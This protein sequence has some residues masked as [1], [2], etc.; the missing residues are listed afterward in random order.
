MVLVTRGISKAQT[1]E[2]IS[3][4]SLVR[5]D[6]TGR[7]YK[8]RNRPKVVSNDTIQERSRRRDKLSLWA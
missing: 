7:E 3:C 2:Y 5:V 6:K 1:A 4:W 8:Y